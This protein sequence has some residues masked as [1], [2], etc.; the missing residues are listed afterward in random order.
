MTSIVTRPGFFG[1]GSGYIHRWWTAG[2]IASL[3]C[4]AAYQPKG[5][6]SLALSYINLASPGTYNAAPGTAPTWDVVNGWKFLTASSQYLGTGIYPSSG[7]SLICRFSNAAAVIGANCFFGEADVGNV[8]R[9]YISG[10][11]ATNTGVRYANGATILVAPVLT[12]GVLA[13]AGQQGHRN[14]VADGGAIGAWSGGAAIY[15]ILI[16]AND[17]TASPPYRAYATGYFQ[18]GAIYNTTLTPAQVLA[19]TNAMNVL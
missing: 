19:V 18:A 13:V 3:T 2:G 12:S 17:Y 9:L 7:W 4:V 10:V 16:G 1:E 15:P 5:A 14:G 6:A 11:D 8:R